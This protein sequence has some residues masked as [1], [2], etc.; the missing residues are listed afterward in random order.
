MDGDYSVVHRGDVVASSACRV[1]VKINPAKECAECAAH[2]FCRSDGGSR[3]E[4]VFDVEYDES[5]IGL[6]KKGD[7]VEIGLSEG[8][9]RDAILLMIVMPLVLLVG[10][11]LAALLCF[12]MNERL[13]VVVGLGLMFVYDLI[14][15]V[16]FRHKIRKKY[17]WS[18]IRRL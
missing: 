8:L 11:T 13:S 7:K 4:T 12:D 17:K 5:G 16:C 14:I 10:S 18:V 6:L 15:F 3:G 2:S 9:H 1:S